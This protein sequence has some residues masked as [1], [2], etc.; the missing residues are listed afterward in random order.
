MEI[1]N[2]KKLSEE[3]KSEIALEVAE[4]K[5][6]GGKIPHLAAVLIGNNP[7]SESYVRSKVRSCDQVGF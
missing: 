1:L 7:A 6:K 4:I 2:G 3:I 5:R